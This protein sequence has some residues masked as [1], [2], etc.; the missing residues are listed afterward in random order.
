M[1]SSNSRIASVKIFLSVQW[2]NWI[3]GAPPDGMVSCTKL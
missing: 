1:S 2:F 3:L